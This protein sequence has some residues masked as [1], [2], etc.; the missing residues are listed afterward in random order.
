MLIPIPSSRLG[1]HPVTFNFVR[2]KFLTEFSQFPPQIKPCGEVDS[3][4]EY[5]GGNLD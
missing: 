2:I 1:Q 4:R 5:I 3:F